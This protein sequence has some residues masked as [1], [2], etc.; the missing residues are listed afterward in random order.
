MRERELVH[1]KALCSI[2]K[3][4][5]Q[6]ERKQISVSI[7]VVAFSTREKAAEFDLRPFLWAKY[8]C[9]FILK[10]P[11]PSTA[12]CERGCKFGECV[13]PNKCRCFPGYTGKTCSQGQYYRP[14]SRYRRTPQLSEAMQSLRKT[15][16]G[17]P[18]GWVVS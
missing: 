14:G 18:F 5:P 10:T 2:R 8:A 7:P 6:R 4:K 16:L 17:P 15:F 3:G 12:T 11:F 1:K 9:S 13:G